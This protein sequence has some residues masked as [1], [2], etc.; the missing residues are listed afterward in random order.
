MF[1]A[2][3]RGCLGY[4]FGHLWGFLDRVE[5]RIA[6]VRSGRNAGDHTNI[7]RVPPVFLANHRFVT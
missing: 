6:T 1:H 5:S 3:P 7:R 4:L 2:K